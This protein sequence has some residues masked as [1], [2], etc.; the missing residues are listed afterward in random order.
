MAAPSHREGA[1]SITPQGD[2]PLHRTVFLRP[3]QEGKIGVPPAVFYL[4]DD[5]VLTETFFPR[6]ERPLNGPPAAD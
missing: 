2:F 5:P 6:G 3:T 4:C 1:P